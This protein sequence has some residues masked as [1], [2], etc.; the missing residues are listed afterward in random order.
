MY[1]PNCGKQI[2]EQSTF[3][4]YCGSQQ[5]ASKSSSKEIKQT[6]KIVCPKCEKDDQIQNVYAIYTNG[7]SSTQLDYR[8]ATSTTQL[9]SRLS[10]PKNKATPSN[11]CV[12]GVVYAFFM[13][14]IAGVVYVMFQIDGVFIGFIGGGIITWL[15]YRWDANQQAIAKAE[16]EKKIKVYFDLYYCY[17]DDCVFNPKTGKYTLPEGMDRLL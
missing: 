14:V 4:A 16:W 6:G 15:I 8:T 9:A 10:P 17:R 5:S 7:T 1:C 2:P 12:W 3:C 11:G 13:A